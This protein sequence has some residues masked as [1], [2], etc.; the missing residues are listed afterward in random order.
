[1]CLSLG[2]CSGINSVKDISQVTIMASSC[3]DFQSHLWDKLYD[4]AIEDEGMPKTSQLVEGL[5]DE[6]KEYL[7]T[8]EIT[9][10]QRNIDSYLSN[11]SKLYTIINEKALAGVDL[12]AKNDILKVL[13]SIEIG[14]STSVEKRTLNNQ[15]KAALSAFQS[16]SRNIGLGCS[17]TENKGFETGSANL[18]YFDDLKKKVN[19]MVYGS[20]KVFATMYQSCEALE[21]APINKNTAS[22]RGLEAIGKHSNGIGTTR[23]I[24]SLGDVVNTHYY[25]KNTSKAKSSCEDNRSKPL[26][27][28]YG[29]K[30]YV[31]SG[32]SSSID[33]FKDAGSGGDELGIDCSAF[34]ISA[35]LSSGLK[36]SPDKDQKAIYIHGINSSMLKKPQ[37]NGLKCLEQIQ[38]TRGKTLMAGDVI[39]KVGHVFAID[40]VG[41]DPYGIKNIKSL[42]ECKAGPISYKNFDFT[43][44]HSSSAKGAMGLTRMVGRDFLATSGSFRRGMEDHAISACYLK[45]GKRRAV[46]HSSVAVVRHKLTSECRA[47][48]VVLEQQACVSRCG[49]S[50]IET[51]ETVEL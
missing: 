11:F 17:V 29:G 26:I 6:L 12:N 5:E 2:A 7:D 31:T 23:R 41:I 45:F 44:V 16:S 34:I 30:P 8:N 46:N 27:Y 4:L 49:V 24:A 18:P 43:I 22:L 32:K 28:D 19:P 10:K 13:A 39:S 48:E 51:A 20:R 1:M 3:T 33:F 40:R 42:S 35:I 50:A 15:L 21:L 36:I 37:E 25:I 9:Y 14:D 47:N 38:F